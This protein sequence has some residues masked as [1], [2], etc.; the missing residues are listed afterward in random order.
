[1]EWFEERALL[2][3]GPFPRQ[4][5]SSSPAEILSPGLVD[6]AWIDGDGPSSLRNLGPDWATGAAREGDS[7]PVTRGSGVF[8][9]Y[10][11][12][13]LLD[14]IQDA[15]NVYVADLSSEGYQVTVAEFT[16]GAAALR[17][18]LQNEWTTRSLE[19]ALLVGDLPHVMFTSV[20]NYDSPPVQ[21][22]YPHDLY[23]M[24]LDGQYTL[25][26]SGPDFHTAGTG[27]VG[28]EIYVSRITT[29]NLGFTGRTEAELI[30]DYF[31]KVHDYRAGILWY[32]DQGIVFADDDWS[33]CGAEDMADLYDYYLV[34]NSTAQTTKTVYMDTLEQNYESILEMTHAWPQGQ[35]I[36]ED[37]VRVTVSNTEILAAN[38]RPGFY[39]MFNCSGA[40][41]TETD[42]LAGTYVYGGDFGL[43]AVGS[44]KTGSMMSFTDYYAPQAAGASVG[45]AFQSWFNLHAAATDDPDR[46]GD[47]DWFYGMTMQ[48]DPT[49]RPKSMGDPAN[50]PDRF[51]PNNGF[52]FATDLGT[53]LNRTEKNLTIHAPND[54][55]YFK[56][57]TTYSG[58][59]NVSITFLSVYGDLNLYLYDSG[60]VLVASSTG[61]SSNYEYINYAVTEGQRYYIKVEGYEG[62]PQRNYSLM[63]DGYISPDRF[64]PNNSFESATNLSLFGTLQNH[65]ENDLSLHEG[66]GGDY[67]KVTTAY[68]GM[69]N[70]DINF[71]HLLGNL[72]LSLLTY[73]MIRV[74]NSAGEGD[75]EHVS[76][77]VTAGQ[78]YYIVVLGATNPDYSLLIDGPNS[79]GDRFE[80]NNTLESATDFGI[81]QDRIEND[82]S[83]HESDNDDYYKLTTACSGTLNVDINF[84]SG[85]GDLNLYLYD[86]SHAIVDVS[87]GFGE[88]EHIARAVSAG[89]V[90]YVEVHGAG[91]QC[92]PNYS[93]VIDG[94]N[95]PADRFEPNNSSG[96]ATNLGVLGDR[97]E[98]NLSIHASSDWDCY[99]FTTATSGTL[100]V[101][102]NFNNSLG[103]LN[104]VLRDASLKYVASSEGTDD[105]EHV[106][107]SVLAGEVYYVSVFG[108]NGQMN[109][110]YSL[111][112]DGPDILPDRFE[113]NDSFVAAANLGTL[114]DRRE[115]ELSIHAAGNDDWYKITAAAS[116]TLNVDINFSNSLGNLD[117]Y[118][119]DSSFS[120][121]ASS[122]GEGDNE[123]L[124]YAVTMDQAYYVRVHG[125]TNAVNPN[126]SL[127]IDGPD[128]HVDRFEPND[129]FT[130]AADLGILGDRTEDSLSAF[131]DDYYKLTAAAPGTLNVDINF[132]NS[133]GN[134]DLY[135]YDSG[136]TLVASSSGSG[137]NEHVSCSVTA[138]QVYYVEVHGAGGATNPY[139]ALVIDGPNIVPD[140]FEP[141]DSFAA[142]TDLGTSGDRTEDNLTIHAAFNQDWY[143]LTTAA[144]GTL[145]VDINFNH[146]LGD[147]NLYLYDSTHASVACSTGAGDNEH[148]SYSVTAGQVYYIEVVGAGSATNADY[149]LVIDGPNVIAPDRFEPNDS[150]AAAVDFGILGDRTEDD[151]S[152]HDAFNHDY[153]KLTTATSGTAMLSVDINFTHSLGN[154]D[155]YLYDASGMQVASSTG[156]GDNE[157]VSCAVTTG[158]VYYVRV[159]GYNGAVNPNYSLVIEGPPVMGD[160][161]E[162]NDSFAAARDLGALG[163]RTENSLSIHAAHNDDYYKLAA[164]ASGTVNADI[165][166]THSQGDLNLYLYDSSQTLVASSTGTG[167][168]EHVSYAVTVGQIYYVKV[169]GL[170]GATNP[171]YSLVID[172]PNISL[173][174]DRFEPNNAFST[175]TNLGTLGDRTEDNLS[176]HAPSND[177]YYKFTTIASGTLNVDINFV[178]SFGNLNL[179]LY[180]AMQGELAHSTGT[181]NNEHLSYEVMA[182]QTCYIKVVGAGGATNASYNL[183][184]DGPNLPAADRFEPNDSFAAAAN[185]GTAGDRTENGLTIHAAN[186]EDYYR[187]TAA[188]SGTL[189]V[190]IN[191]SQ[192]YGNLNLYLYD[193]SQTLVA[194]STGVGNNEHVSYSVTAGQVYYVKVVGNSG[195][196]NPDY[197]LVIDGPDIPADRFEPNDSLGAAADLGTLGDRTEDN[198]SIHA[199]DDDCYKLTT[200]SSGTLNVDI[201]FTHAFGDLVLCLY[202]SSQQQVAFSQGQG[203]NEHISYSVTAGQVYYVEV[204]P[205]SGATNPNY[206]LLVDGPDAIPGDANRDGYVDD[207]DASILGANWRSSSATW[208]TGDFNED[209]VVNDKD[210]AILAAHWHLGTPPSEEGSPDTLLPNGPVPPGEAPL[211]GPILLGTSSAP[212]R[213]IEPLPAGRASGEAHCEAASPQQVAARDAVFAETSDSGLD[214]E[215][216]LLRHRLAWSYELAQRRGPKRTAGRRGA[217]A[218]RVDVLLA[219]GMM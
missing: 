55:D 182:G 51:E 192:F 95:I 146:F 110:D 148:V 66:D 84:S 68:S 159:C 45:E 206:S 180:N 190:D 186:N 216:E 60:H 74:A 151:L 152:I 149:S 145:N 50:N 121:V 142:A 158:L 85:W 108:W 164:G 112:I 107:V 161:F 32:E 48:G 147:L 14:D 207:M 6:T 193:S 214:G 44:T 49:L 124:S 189:T 63:I 1:M 171:N 26:A 23:F 4:E 103:D 136:Q 122:A 27:D 202:N 129:S 64:E 209:G 154:L 71:N 125:R 188:S 92:H 195:A 43:N 5:Q 102:I 10:V 53:A 141:N 58:A 178:H 75:N 119:W 191:F 3:V 211:I 65:T 77:A 90:Y 36:I 153:F 134:L 8:N 82:L 97:T 109:P 2:S 194:S 185:L 139:Y 213:R 46:D 78:T 179:Y 18:D 101:D 11:E 163:D 212:R 54:V 156:E 22:T 201:N 99:R 9:V 118:L 116:G 144:P 200:R 96:A 132:N 155:L 79:P 89:E 218:P 15:I 42:Y 160:R 184:I 69:L 166:F 62:Q 205:L 7:G 56:L 111:V 143:K 173:L 187:L 105:N 30:N 167:D 31:A 165:N 219:A 67:F 135:L 138:G 40:R 33:G 38:P 113:P 16:G 127:V 25:N 34:V 87:I 150:F 98:D 114:G 100:N 170:G 61:V 177:D 133:L 73:N 81:V 181:G 197:S 19:G 172:G 117:L 72:D 204:Y 162:P 52:G 208:E 41:F 175:A 59:L 35:Q 12:P 29:G 169:C 80:P 104:L 199:H 20:D 120:Q 93:L 176:I 128:D 94:P 88:N 168:N 86:A 28:P 157:H 115:D 57:T 126:Y 137:N 37:P 203:D 130:A 91:G 39:N 217:D 13:G 106:S 196:T 174:P 183:V 70:V 21:V 131:N 17:A 47:V 123:H 210:A 215:T 140:R 83:I 76:R 198:L 24:D